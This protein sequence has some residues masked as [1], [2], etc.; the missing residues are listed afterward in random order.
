MDSQENLNELKYKF[1]KYAC[2]AIV[3]MTK[4]MS[5]VVKHR[6]VSVISCPFAGMLSY[7]FP[8]SSTNMLSEKVAKAKLGLRKVL[9]DCSNHS[10]RFW[11]KF[12]L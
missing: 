5:R 2:K 1:R 8:L 7:A 11:S 6:R 12:N 10:T 4:L 3:V 9:T